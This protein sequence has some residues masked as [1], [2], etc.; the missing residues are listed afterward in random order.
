MSLNSLNQSPA[1]NDIAP[2]VRALTLLLGARGPVIPADVTAEQL[3]VFNI[4]DHVALSDALARLRVAG[5]VVGDG[6]QYSLRSWERADLVAFG[7]AKCLAAWLPAPPAPVR[8]DL[9]NVLFRAGRV[10][11]G[12][13]QA[14][15]SGGVIDEAMRLRSSE[16][17]G[18]LAKMLGVWG[19]WGARAPALAVR[20][21]AH[22]LGGLG[23]QVERQEDTL[24]RARVLLNDVR[25][26]AVDAERERDAWKARA[27]AAEAQLRSI[28]TAEA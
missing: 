7:P 10:I 8:D 1:T 19:A 24:L 3:A 23:D 22:G 6:A 5:V 26:R 14:E 11:S 15:R 17:S 2:L 9:G 18:V 27:E 4:I 28:T 12:E 16:I 21:E 13:V 25:R 20:G